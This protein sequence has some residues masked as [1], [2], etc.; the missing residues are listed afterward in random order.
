[1][2]KLA[3]IVLIMTVAAA[4]ATDSKISPND[5]RSP[6]PAPLTAFSSWQPI[7]LIRNGVI[8][9]FKRKDFND[10]LFEYRWKREWVVSSYVCTVELRHAEDA[11]DS[12]T[13]PEIDVF[14]GDRN[15]HDKPHRYIV[16]DVALGGKDGHVL[17]KQAD[18]EDI[19][20]VAWGK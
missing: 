15:N 8:N 14:Y 20:M 16:H 17:L 1:M 19:G 13:L 12:H 4:G 5:K 3:S 7:F 9:T 6:T 18:C 2:G 10:S 11:E